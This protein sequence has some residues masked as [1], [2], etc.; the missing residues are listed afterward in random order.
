MA[1]RKRQRSFLTSLRNSSKKGA[2]RDSRRRNLVEKL[3]QRQLLAGPQL[4][5]I[6]PDEGSLIIDGT[7]RDVSP[8]LLTFRFD[9]DQVIHPSTTDA[10]RVSRAGADGDLGTPD[11]VVV[12]LPAG[13]VTVNSA[14]ANEVLVRFPGALP[15][16]EYRIEVFAFDDADAGIVGLRNTNASGGVGELLIPGTAGTRKEQ[17]DFELQLG[18]LVESVVPQ[19]V[20]RLANGTLTQRRDQI[21]VYFNEDELFVENYPAGHALAGSPTPRSAENPR[22]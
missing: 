16:D 22:F 8:R 9:E 11:D 6:Q 2:S 7:V 13:S 4:I 12:D 18:A 19:P 20:V 14:A 10:I 3:E 17:V 15:D 21:V 5:G 1:S